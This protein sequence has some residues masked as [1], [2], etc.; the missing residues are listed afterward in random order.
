MYF[1]EE[2]PCSCLGTLYRGKGQISRKRQGDG[3][4]IFKRQINPQHKWDIER[5]NT[6]EYVETRV[7][8]LG[9][10]GFYEKKWKQNEEDGTQMNNL[11]PYCFFF[12]YKALQR[13]GCGRVCM[14]V[15]MY[16]YPKFVLVLV[17]CNI[18]FHVYLCV[19]LHIYIDIYCKDSGG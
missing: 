3:T 12:F 1:K 11:G 13:V 10:K 14:Y 18:I 8:P 19:K 17:F 4:Q 15:C 2:A 9:T 16:R 7:N 6:K 5:C